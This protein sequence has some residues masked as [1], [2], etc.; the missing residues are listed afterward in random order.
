VNV[1]YKHLESKLRIGELTV[2]QWAGLLCGVGL[3]IGW[4]LY[5]SPFGA[6]LTLLSAI[7]LGGIPAAAAF[8]ASLS[9]FDLWLLVRCAL[10]WHRAEGRFAPGAGELASGYVVLAE[11]APAPAPHGALGEAELEGLWES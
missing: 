1:A 6:Y 7:Y 2:G 4:G 8:V 3:A 9:E 10:V 11:P 5:L